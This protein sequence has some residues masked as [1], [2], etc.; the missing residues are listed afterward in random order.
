MAGSEKAGDGKCTRTQEKSNGR[1]RKF[2]QWKPIGIQGK[3]NGRKVKA[4]DGKGTR[5][6]GKEGNGKTRK[7]KN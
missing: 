2:R 1:G 7:G 5:S 4:G 6:Q 3:I